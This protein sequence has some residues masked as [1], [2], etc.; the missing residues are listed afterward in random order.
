MNAYKTIIQPQTAFGT[1]LVGDTLF[2]QICWGIVEQYGEDK[3]TAC[4]QDYTA[5]K[6]F[7][8][9]S[10]AMPENHL[11]LPT[12][13]SHYWTQGKETDRKQLKKRQWLPE[14]DF[15]EKESHLWQQ[16]AKRNDDIESHL[17]TSQQQAH[18]S[19][20][21]QSGTTGTDAFAPFE[22]EQIWFAA[23]SQWQIYLLLDQTRL[24]P[25]EL[26]T[27]LENIG[28]MGYGRD[29]SSGLG[30][31]AIVDLITSDL[32]QS[33]QGNALLT[34]SACCPQQQHYSGSL[35]FY[36][37]LTRFGRH[38][39]TQ[40]TAGNPFKKPVLMAQTGA[41]FTPTDLTNH[42][43]LIGQGVGNISDIQP[44]AVHQGYAPA[45]A[46]TL[47]SQRLPESKL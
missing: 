28:K 39:N 4:L 20:N 46:F 10:D 22:S 1:P 15:R 37:T 14:S 35:S 42:T 7:L 24:S 6:P 11:P 45:L 29:A 19:L 27:I 9:V 25:Q 30:K 34:L 26:K 2:G 47:D 8:V 3:L 23:N 5:G 31:Y 16:S 36:N 41:V 32:F 12:L 18:N 43:G 40:A 13:P 44:S 17:I 38:G 33:N 21:R